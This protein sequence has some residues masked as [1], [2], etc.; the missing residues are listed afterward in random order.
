MKRYNN[1]FTL[2]ELLV[3]LAIV[4][5]VV[6]IGTP[7]F[8]NT[9]NNSRLTAAVNEL[10]ATMNLA[11]SEAIK[12]NKFVIV[13]RAGMYTVGD[14]T[15]YCG[16]EGSSWRD[17]WRVFV[18]VDRS[19]GNVN[20]FNDNG[21]SNLCEPTEDCLLKIQEPLATNISL[22]PSGANFDKIVRFAPTGI[23]DNNSVGGSFYFCSPDS[24]TEQPD[25]NSSKVLV[26][27]GIGRPRIAVDNYDAAKQPKND[28]IPEVNFQTNITT[29]AP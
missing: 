16:E 14:F 27:N 6:M 1:G 7:S 4:S 25:A 2:L 17:G 18:D 21:D 29:C 8:Q 26:L 24:G 28:G 3:T 20:I 12:R 13:C 11:R 10:S 22:R 5:I 9:I 19:A 15:G 23:V